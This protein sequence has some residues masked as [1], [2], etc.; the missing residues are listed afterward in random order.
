MANYKK[1]ALRI[2][3]T[4]ISTA[5]SYGKLRNSC[6][7]VVFRVHM[8]PSFLIFYSAFYL[9]HYAILHFTHSICC[10]C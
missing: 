2:R 5:L 7:H 9:T 8:S 1:V 3:T 6:C 10:L 4:H